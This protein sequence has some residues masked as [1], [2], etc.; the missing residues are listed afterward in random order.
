M[1][2]HAKRRSTKAG[3]PPG[4]LVH[5]GARKTAAAH[6]TLLDYDAEWRT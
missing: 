2:S 1:S 6:I 3:L 5:I 4:T